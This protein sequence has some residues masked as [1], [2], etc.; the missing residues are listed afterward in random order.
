MSLTSFFSEEEVLSLGFQSIGKGCLISRNACFYDIC[1]ISIGNN[2]RIDDFCIISGNIHIGSNI[3][4]SAYVAL[5]GSKGI[6]IED[7]SGISPR[8][9]IFS[10]LD[11]FSGDYLIGPIHSV[12][13]TNVQ[14][15]PV[16]L[17]R[18]SQLGANNVVFPNSIIGEGAATGAYT[19]VKSSLPEWKIY[20]GIPA[21]EL[22]QR[23]KGLLRFI[24]NRDY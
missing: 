21:R 13:S 12:E 18:Y 10:A 1:R 20:I 9:T 24:K 22:R 3:H 4:I 19:L 16:V 7:Y 11:D 2:V 15:G 14:S 8:T 17:K 6:Y 5:Y 23:N